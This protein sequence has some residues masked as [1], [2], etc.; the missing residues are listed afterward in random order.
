MQPEAPAVLLEDTWHRRRAQHRGTAIWSHWALALAVPKGL[1]Y[2]NQPLDLQV[3]GEGQGW[4]RKT[5]SLGQSR[6]DEL[7]A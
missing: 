6:E 1:S 7:V 5:L 3:Q 2:L 4:S